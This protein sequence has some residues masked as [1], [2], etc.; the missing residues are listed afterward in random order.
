MAV[1]VTSVDVDLFSE[2][3]RESAVR[4]NF[5]SILISR[6]EHE[7]KGPVYRMSRLFGCWREWYGSSLKD[8]LH[9]YGS[10]LFS[11]ILFMPLF[12]ADIMGG[13]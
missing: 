5:G 11:A 10:E 13:I 2:L 6:R 9:C 3:V 12:L 8:A 4:L 1:S 7:D